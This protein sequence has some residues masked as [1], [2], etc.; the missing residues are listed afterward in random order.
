MCCASDLKLHCQNQSQ[1]KNPNVNR[2]PFTQDG[3]LSLNYQDTT[4]HQ[5]TFT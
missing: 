2:I 5:P 1:N 3:K 4:K